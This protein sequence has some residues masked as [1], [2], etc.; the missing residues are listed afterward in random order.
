MGSGGGH[1]RV[2]LVCV[3]DVEW[4]GERAVGGRGDEVVELVRAARGGGDAV[5]GLQCGLGELPAEAAG[6]AGDEPDAGVGGVHA[7]TVGA[8]RA[9]R[10]HRLP[11]S[12]QA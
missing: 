3:G 9:D 1:G 5:A 11:A 7:S 2:D 12:P 8:R 6:A 10:K 4:Q